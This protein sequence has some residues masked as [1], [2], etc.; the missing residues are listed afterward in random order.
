[1]TDSLTPLQADSLG[2]P[3]S[4]DPFFRTVLHLLRAD[5]Y[6]RRQDRDAE[7]RELQWQENNDVIGRP[8]G[9]PQVGDV[10]W[11]FR[12]LARWRQARVLDADNDSRRCELYRAVIREWSKGDVRYRA[13][14]DSAARR[15]ASLACRGTS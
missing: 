14:A 13:R 3:E 2:D 9:P 5:W 1:V 6:E 10:D 8:D 7:V 15:V 11:G 12:T 4:F